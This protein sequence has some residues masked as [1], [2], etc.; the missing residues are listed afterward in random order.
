MKKVYRLGAAL[1]ALLLML[2]GCQTGE[3]PASGSSQSQE[4]SSQSASSEAP[5]ELPIPGI[6]A[7]IRQGNPAPVKHAKSQLQ[8]AFDKHIIS[9]N[10]PLRPQNPAGASQTAYES[11]TSST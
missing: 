2:A 10:S 3:A 4:E 8:S 6:G 7:E 11:F 5:A 9:H 1:L